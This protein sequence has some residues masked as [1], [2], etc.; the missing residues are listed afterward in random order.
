MVFQLWQ[1][2]RYH[3]SPVSS[4]GNIDFDHCKSVC[5]QIQQRPPTPCISWLLNDSDGCSNDNQL[6]ISCG[7]Q[8]ISPLLKALKISNLK[9]KIM[10]KP[11]YRRCWQNHLSH[12]SYWHS[13]CPVSTK[14][15]LSG[16]NLQ[17]RIWIYIPIKRAPQWS[18]YRLCR[19]F[20]W[21]SQE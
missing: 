2:Y 11:L 6:N 7:S 3:N 12:R 13:K 20:E 17:I 19:W 14:T 1:N 8:G 18:S 16:I 15:D 21:L 10:S 4:Q 9:S 5:I